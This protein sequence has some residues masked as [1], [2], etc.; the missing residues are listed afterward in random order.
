[1]EVHEQVFSWILK[2]LKKQGL[3][4]GKTLGLDSTMLEANAAMRSIVRRDTMLGYTEFLEELAKESGIEAPTREALAKLDKQRSKKASNQDWVHPH[5][6]DARI[7]NMKD[8]TTHMAHKLEHTLD[9]DTGAIVSTTVQTTDG[10]DCASMPVTL[11]AAEAQL[12][13]VEI[14]AKEVVAD[15]GYHSNDTL[16]KLKERNVRS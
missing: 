13:A 7:A 6:P 5:D 3:L 11:D 14:S 4:L 1:M 2:R 12:A 9:L 16:T 8:G 10:G 15:K